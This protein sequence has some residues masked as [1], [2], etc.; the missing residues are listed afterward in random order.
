MKTQWDTTTYPPDWLKFKILREQ[1]E[2]G[3]GTLT[4]LIHHWWGNK[5][6]Q[7][8]WETDSTVPTEDEY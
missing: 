7:L 4:A 2:Q 3:C 8:L 1:G 5:L 6:V